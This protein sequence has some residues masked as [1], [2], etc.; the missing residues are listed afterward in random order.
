MP[1]DSWVKDRLKNV[2]LDGEQ[3][4]TLIFKRF[5][6]DF[7]E[8]RDDSPDF[9]HKMELM[10]Y[11]EEER[12]SANFNHLTSAYRDL[13]HTIRMS[14]DRFRHS[15]SCALLE[16]AREFNPQ[17]CRDEGRQIGRHFDLAVINS[18]VHF[19]I[20][21]IRTDLIRRFFCLRGTLTRTS[22]VS[23]ALIKDLCK[24]R[25]CGGGIPNVQ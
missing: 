5:S 9:Q 23:P 19:T 8:Q 10:K 3:E 4:V 12:I 17:Y 6:T 20:G 1:F 25:L 15:F 11:K 2:I 14:F 22:E 13:S 24:S 21:D 7:R 18:L 16:N